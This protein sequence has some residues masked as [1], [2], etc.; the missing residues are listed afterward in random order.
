MVIAAGRVGGTVIVMRTILL[1][2]I[3]K[4]VIPESRKG[5]IEK[6]KPT[7]AKIANIRI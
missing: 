7:T 1:K 4:A 3:S 6:Q 2:T 5:L